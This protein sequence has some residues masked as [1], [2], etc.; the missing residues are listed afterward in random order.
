MEPPREI[1]EVILFLASDRS[2]FI[3]GATLAVDAGRTACAPAIAAPSARVRGWFRCHRPHPVFL[4]ALTQIC[5]NAG[6]M[7]LSA[8]TVSADR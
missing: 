8:L 6:H 3:T 5:D 4:S 7:L 1:A 2:S